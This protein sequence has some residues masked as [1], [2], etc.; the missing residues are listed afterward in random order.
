M[1]IKRLIFNL[2]I[3]M[4]IFSCQ[5]DKN[6]VSQNRFTI[7]GITS[8]DDH[9][10]IYLLNNESN[11]IDSSE[12]TKLSFKFRGTVK[13]SSSYHLKFKNNTKTYPIILDNNKFIVFISN[14]NAKIYGGKLN[15]KLN[16]FIQ[17]KNT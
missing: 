8:S 5:K 13:E 3:I 14:D 16:K 17:E 7:T 4:L 1:K 12:I 2:L 9:K 6:E 10:L 15:N 11:I